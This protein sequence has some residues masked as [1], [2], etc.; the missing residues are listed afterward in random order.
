MKALQSLLHRIDRLLPLHWPDGGDHAIAD[1]IQTH[2][3][4]AT[5][6]RIER[7]AAGQALVRAVGPDYLRTLASPLL[8][9][10]RSLSRIGVARAAQR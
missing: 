5:R 10:A 8:P 1:E 9:G 2:L 3:D 4:M 7:G 6:E